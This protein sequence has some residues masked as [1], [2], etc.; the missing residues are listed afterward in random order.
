[1][2]SGPAA[3]AGLRSER[4]TLFLSAAAITALAVAQPL[5]DLLGRSPEFFTARAAPASDVVL[6]GLLLGLVIP[7]TAGAVVLA[8]HRFSP[9]AGRVVHASVIVV[10]GALLTLAVLA[11]TP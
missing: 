1:M 5:L 8:V 6:L 4:A 10:S 7:L 3:G 2:S 11:H 9:A